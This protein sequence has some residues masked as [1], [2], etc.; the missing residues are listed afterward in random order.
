MDANRV[1][2]SIHHEYPLAFP[3]LQATYYSIKLLA[4]ENRAINWQLNQRTGEVRTHCITY[5]FNIVNRHFKLSWSE[6]PYLDPNDAET[7]CHIVLMQ[8]DHSTQTVTNLVGK[9]S[10]RQHYQFTAGPRPTPTDWLICSVTL[11]LWSTANKINKIN[12]SRILQTHFLFQ[13][14]AECWVSLHHPAADNQP[15]IELG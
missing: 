14:M 15:T 11:Q 4:T 9:Q 7:E 8:A 13:T 12:P 5:M 1:T 6:S 2:T 10:Y 3:I